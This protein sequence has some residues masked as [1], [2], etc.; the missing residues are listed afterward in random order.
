MTNRTP[1]AR[2][3]I[4]GGGAGEISNA[5]IERRA[6]EIARMDGRIDV[7]DHDRF[8]ARNELS[9]SG[10]PPPDEFDETIANVQ[11]WDESPASHGHRAPRIGPDDEISATETLINEGLEEADRD[12]RLSASTEEE[13]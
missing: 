11:A 7:T 8:H 12:Q 5:D 9:S 2:I 3:E 10:A 13:E 1:T 4:H 6:A